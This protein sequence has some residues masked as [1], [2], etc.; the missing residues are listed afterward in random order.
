MNIELKAIDPWNT[1]ADA[2]IV[3]VPQVEGAPRLDAIPVESLREQI[4]PLLQDASFTGK[5]GSTYLISTLGSSPARRLVLAGVG[6]PESLSGEAIRKAWGAAIT[7]ARDAGAKKIVSLLPPSSE[8]LSADQALGDAVSAVGMATY[9]Y[10][11]QQGTVK[12]AKPVKSVDSLTFVSPEKTSKS[13]TKF[14]NQGQAVSAAVNLA[15]DV[16]ND[17]PN[18]LTPMKFAD[19][20]SEVAK[21]HGLKMKLFDVKK[22]EKLG[23]N[24]ILTVGKGSANPPCMIHLTYTP[25]SATQNTPAVGLVGKCITFDTGGYS[26]KPADGMGE[27]KG[28]M[29]GGAAVLGAMAAVAELEVPVTVHAVICAAENM[30][31]GDAYRPSDVIVGM[32]GVTMEIISTD[33]EGRL[34]MADGLVYLSR[35]GVREMIDVSTL[36]G[37]KI[38]ALGNETVALFA[39]NDKLASGLLAAADEAAEPMWRLPLSEH[40]E[41]QIEAE[42]ADIKN[43][44]GR[45]GGAIT[46]GLFLQHFSEGLPWA[47][48]DIAGANRSSKSSAYAPK[49]STGVMVRTLLNYLLRAGS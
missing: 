42:V 1:A 32:N 21:A 24:A 9:T 30:I 11:A 6:D 27:M 41:S 10:T 47:H 29:G 46:A 16:S 35:Q 36:T 3:P 8:S 31:S 34:V 39:N 13:Q 40:L 4:A 49:G 7:R 5:V 2:L 20:A 25:K 22:L 48:L 37:A 12:N 18:D 26:I 15:R 14:F 28:D 19:V 23:A 38:I 44:G 43:T 17:P 45:P 33:A